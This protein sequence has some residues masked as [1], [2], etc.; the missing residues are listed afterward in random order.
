[1]LN[2]LIRSTCNMI[3]IGSI[4]DLT[5]T[6]AQLITTGWKQNQILLL[7][8]TCI[9]SGDGSLCNI[10]ITSRDLSKTGNHSFHQKDINLT[11][12]LRNYCWLTEKMMHC[13][14]I[15]LNLLFLIRHSDRKDFTYT[16]LQR[17]IQK[18]SKGG[19]K[20]FTFNKSD[21]L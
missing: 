19:L 6:C 9:Q 2:Y 21:V 4:L 7:R 18:F 11:F 8:I 10:A 5:H 13:W 20:C 15:K 3:H 16:I 14:I 12:S 1:M 17:R